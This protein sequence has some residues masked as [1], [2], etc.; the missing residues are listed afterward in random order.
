M[1]GVR[2]EIIRG[3]IQKIKLYRRTINIIEKKRT[4]QTQM[5]SEGKNY[6]GTKRFKI[7]CTKEM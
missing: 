7:T 1:H 5:L 6:C 2:N 3:I 4:T